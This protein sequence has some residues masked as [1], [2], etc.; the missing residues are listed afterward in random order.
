MCMTN[1]Q[2]G[3]G[4]GLGSRPVSPS[5]FGWRDLSGPGISRGAVHPPEGET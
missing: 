4:D 5:V 3:V 1:G 2:T